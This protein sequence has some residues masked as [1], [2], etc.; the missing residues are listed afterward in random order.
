MAIA[1]HKPKEERRKQV[2]NKE[3]TALASSSPYT[4]GSLTSFLQSTAAAS[5]PEPAQKEGKRKLAREDTAKPQKKKKSG[6]ESTQT[7]DLQRLRAFFDS[8]LKPKEAADTST[9][10]ISCNQVT[11]RAPASPDGLESDGRTAL[12][13]ERA[14]ADVGAAPTTSSQKSCSLTA[15][16]S[17]A[18]PETQCEVSE[19]S[20]ERPPGRDSEDKLQR[21]LFIGNLPVRDQFKPIELYR[22][23]GLS[24]MQVES[25]R[26]RS[27][28]IAAQFRNCRRA[29]IARQQ[30]SSECDQQNAYLV[31]KD[32]SLFPP[33]RGRELRLD[34]ATRK[35]FSLFDRK[36]SVCVGGLPKSATESDLKQGLCCFGPVENSRVVR[37]KVTRMSKGFGFV[38]FADRGSATKAVLAATCTIFGR[39]VRL[40]RALT[41]GECRAKKT[42][43]QKGKEAFHVG[44][45]FAQFRSIY[46]SCS[47]WSLSRN[48]KN[49][50]SPAAR[51]ILARKERKLQKRHIN[52]ATARVSHN[53][54]LTCL[55]S[56]ILTCHSF[57]AHIL[58][59]KI[60]LNISI[61]VIDRDIEDTYPEQS[62][63]PLVL[64]P[65]ALRECNYFRPA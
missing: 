30:F 43:E 33:F 2:T 40:M 36:R 48:G 19:A 34:T 23:L 15:A 45:H 49:K 57:T 14:C 1:V 26:L 28:P 12:R 42:E 38:C 56:C 24:K 61:H 37:D 53:C 16:E 22:H 41:E 8:A 64:S 20:E 21:T 39:P 50:F 62:S 59:N 35:G 32:K 60:S 52:R 9:N 55:S 29:A 13:L 51:R 31:L 63:E 5:A 3:N 11:R 46:S 7:A 54:R 47:A 10:K 44:L 4:P 18:S 25:M 17:T 58:H 27:V 65:S 6:N